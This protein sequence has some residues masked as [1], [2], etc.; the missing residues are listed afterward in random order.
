MLGF[1][2]SVNFFV[3]LI[4]AIPSYRAG[5]SEPA[6]YHPA[7]LAV[8]FL[9]SFAFGKWQRFALIGIWALSLV[10]IVPGLPG[11]F[12]D[13]GM[14]SIVIIAYLLAGLMGACL[15]PNKK[16]AAEATPTL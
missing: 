8:M 6:F 15:L 1:Q 14:T 13:G 7:L 4:I 3:F 2:A 5:V 10:L 11:G 9:G 16:R 12:M